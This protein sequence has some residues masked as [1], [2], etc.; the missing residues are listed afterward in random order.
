MRAPGKVS[1]RP[2]LSGLRVA[3]ATSSPCAACLTPSRK[4][5]AI[6]PGPMIPQR[7]FFSVMVVFLAWDAAA[8]DGARSFFCG[9]WPRVGAGSADSLA[10][11]IEKIGPVGAYRDRDAV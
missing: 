3:M 8:S 11:L 4:A 10:P 5:W 7:T 2:G 6:P 1:A 9:L